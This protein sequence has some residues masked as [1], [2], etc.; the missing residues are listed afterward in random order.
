MKL[1]E[2]PS[3]LLVP[4]TKPEPPPEHPVRKVIREAMAKVA[5]ELGNFEQT[6]HGILG[7]GT[8]YSVAGALARCY[9]DPRAYTISDLNQLIDQFVKAAQ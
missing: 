9:E 6:T 5:E 3:G 2:R 1:Q 8:V 7:D 4:A